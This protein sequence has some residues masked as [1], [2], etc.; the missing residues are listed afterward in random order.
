M[1]RLPGWSEPWAAVAC[2]VVGLWIGTDV[3]ARA[4]TRV[5][6]IVL[7]RTLVIIVLLM[8]A[9][10]AFKVLARLLYC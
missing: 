7:R 9:Y 10:M 6:E 5:R 1:H 8:A 3:S 4:A 2:V